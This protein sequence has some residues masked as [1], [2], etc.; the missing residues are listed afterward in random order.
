MANYACSSRCRHCAYF[1]GPEWSN[2]YIGEDAARKTL[3]ILKN[4]GCSSVH[5]GGGE[6]FLGRERLVD[7][8]GWCF[9][10]GVHV[11]YVETNASWYNGSDGADR[12]LRE[13]SRC[14]L[15]TLL[16]S[17]SPFHNEFVPW[18]KTRDLIEACRNEGVAVFPW[19]EGFVPDISALDA[20]AT[21]SIEEYEQLYGE[22]YLEG[23]PSRY[24]ISPRGRA[25]E[26]FRRFEHRRSAED[27]ADRSP[28]ACRELYDTS[29]FHV[30]LYGNF[31]PGVCSGLSIAID[32]LDGDIDPQK[33]PFI[34]RLMAAGI[35]SLL[36]TAVR[37]HG[38][39]PRDSYGGKC[40][41]CYH[42]R[43]FLVIEQNILSADLQPAE[44]YSHMRPEA[45]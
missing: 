17:I 3:R 43:R 19:V 20:D 1:S 5:I 45:V 34:T 7:L 26:T 16:I 29:H 31:I 33:Y 13:V 22:G 30:D 44:L 15:D 37:T 32:D 24:W 39:V 28:G 41:L 6:P 11:E 23:L 27:I 36:D 10:E 21:H 18:R 38:F 4:H 42:I 12:L 2:D 40:D 9:D 8:V 35:R 14:G 25:V